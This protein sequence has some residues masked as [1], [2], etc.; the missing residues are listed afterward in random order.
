M[1]ARA[2]ERRETPPLQAYADELVAVATTAIDHGLVRGAPPEVDVAAH[3]PPLRAERAAFVTLLDADGA[4]RG[5]VGS[6]EAERPLVA[7]V[8]AN[9][10]A[11][12]FQD[13]RFPPLV[14]AERPGLACKLSVLTPAEPIEFGDEAELLGRL[15]PGVDGVLVEAGACR[16][17]FLPAVWEQIPEPA[18]FWR[19]LKQKAGLD[20][21]GLPADLAVYRYRAESIG[22]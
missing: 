13:P 15:E 19:T 3:S 11:A 22:R 1:S 17:T 21:D 2:D 6:I 7:D 5:C 20:P 16:A 14:P 12:A 8:S 18:A 9:A 10:F 4:L